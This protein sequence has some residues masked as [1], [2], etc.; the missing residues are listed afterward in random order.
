MINHFHRMLN[1]ESHALSIQNV[2]KKKSENIPVGWS[3]LVP[4]KPS[5]HKQKYPAPVKILGKHSPFTQGFGWHGPPPITNSNQ[6]SSFNQNEIFQ[7][8]PPC[9]SQNST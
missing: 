1:T 3:Q 9:D 4:W 6:L 7:H 8:K 5:E 2:K